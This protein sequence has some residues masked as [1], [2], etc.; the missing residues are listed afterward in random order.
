MN[1]IDLAVLPEKRR[2]I[3]LLIERKPGSFE[4]IKSLLDIT[5]ASLRLHINKLLYSGLLEEKRGEYK[6]S[7]TAI[8]IIENLKGLLNSL[9]C[10]EENMGYWKKH[11]L[12]PVPDFLLRRLEDLGR[13]ELIES[14]ASH[15]FEIPQVI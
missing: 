15:M 2:D 7:C 6:L 14:D 13:F 4:E 10:F 1:L 11:D 9:A 8:P 5:S 12:T 3:L